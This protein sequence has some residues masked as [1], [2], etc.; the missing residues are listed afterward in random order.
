MADNRKVEVEQEAGDRPP[1]RQSRHLS[2]GVAA[3]RAQRDRLYDEAR[4]DPSSE[5]S[6][7]V[8][9]FLLS[10]LLAIRPEARGGAQL[11]GPEALPNGRPGADDGS[12]SKLERGRP[13]APESARGARRRHDLET[14]IREQDL[15]LRE[16][17]RAA[18][19]ATTA[20]ASGQ[21][22]DAMAVYNQIAEI[23]GLRPPRGGGQNP[24]APCSSVP[25]PQPE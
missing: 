18:R 25:N 12:G 8:R 2:A 5:A 9:S 10:G 14:R 21:P 17:A 19:E 22:M 3:L 7:L 24:Q 6:E 23:V 16:V 15:K 4:E 11:D 20:A 1:E 13:S